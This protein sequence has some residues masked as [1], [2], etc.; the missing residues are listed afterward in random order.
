MINLSLAK[1]IPETTDTFLIQFDCPFGDIN[2]MNGFIPCSEVSFQNM[3]I[4]TREFQVN[5]WSVEVP[6]LIV[7][8]PE[9]VTITVIDDHNR[10]IIQSIKDYYTNH[11]ALLKGRVPLNDSKFLSK[12]WIRRF[13]QDAK[14]V[15]TEAFKFYFKD[16][17]SSLL[18]ST[19]QINSYQLEMTIV[20]TIG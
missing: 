9:T 6:N 18:S 3:R 4:T 11:P 19:K 12:V 15:S 14:L 10:K 1:I 2:I 13:N 8:F 5:K 20:N 16:I 7:P 17:G